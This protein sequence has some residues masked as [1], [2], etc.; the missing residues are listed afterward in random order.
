[1]SAV[2][3]AC[4]QAVAAVGCSTPDDHLATGPDRL[5]TVSTGGRAG[6]SG[7][8]PAIA[9][10][11]VSAASVKEA[12]APDDHLVN[13]G[14]CPNRGVIF[15]RRGCTDGTCCNPCVRG[16][17]VFS[18][19]VHA[20]EATDKLAAAVNLATPDN[21]LAAGPDGGISESPSGRVRR[22][23]GSPAIG[24]RVVFPAGVEIKMI[25]LVPP[26]PDDHFCAAPNRGVTKAGSRRV[27]GA[28]ANPSVTGGIVLAAAVDN[29]A[30]AVVAAPDN[31]FASGP[32]CTVIVA[33]DGCTGSSCCGPTVS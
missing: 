13:R 11:S 21:H 25:G 4:G 12:S 9:V 7:R 17:S 5:L 15:S 24:T 22:C 6:S 2:F 16:R 32:D 27:G 3:S 19:S 33:P 8:R 23:R 29:G 28:G 30:G 14:I 26:T 1:L 31:H 10:G 18:A 20:K